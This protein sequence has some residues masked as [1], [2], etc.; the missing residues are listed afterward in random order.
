MAILRYYFFIDHNMPPKQST[1]DE[2]DKKID[3][4]LSSFKFDLVSDLKK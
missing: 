3:E 4:K 2:L 1:M